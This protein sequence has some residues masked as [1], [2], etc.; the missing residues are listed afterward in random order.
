MPSN[1]AEARKIPPIRKIEPSCFTSVERKRSRVFPSRTHFP[2]L[3][4]ASSA[5][6]GS[7][8]VPLL[9][10]FSNISKSCTSRSG[11]VPDAV[12]DTQ[13]S[14]FASN[15]RFKQTFEPGG[16]FGRSPSK[17]SILPFLLGL[18]GELDGLGP[19]NPEVGSKGVASVLAAGRKNNLMGPAD[20]SLSSYEAAAAK[21]TACACR[22]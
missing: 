20:R 21:L 2:F 14:L 5:S 4:R 11:P 15:A 3:H 6:K 1:S 8:Y 12:A 13:V 16:L 19:Q 7:R 22:G 9:L 18:T 17:K 10:E